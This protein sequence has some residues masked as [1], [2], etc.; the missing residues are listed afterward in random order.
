MNKKLKKLVEHVNML[1][2]NCKEDSPEY[3]L[4]ENVLTDEMIDLAL[5]MKIRTPYTVEMIAQKSKM[6]IETVK[7]LTGKMAYIGFLEYTKLDGKEALSLPVFAPGSMELMVMNKEQVE[8]HP[9]IARSF[10]TYV[11]NLTK[12]FA[13]FFPKGNGLVITIPVQKAIEAEPKRIEIEELTYWV[14]K[15]A[16]SLSVTGCQCRRAGRITNNIGEDKEG[17]WCIQVGEFAESCIKTGRSRRVTKEEAYDILRRAEEMG[18]VHEVTN[19]DGPKNSLFICNCHPETCLAFRTAR[20]IDTPNMMKSN[21]VA[22]VDREKCAACGQCVEVCPMNAAKLGQKLCQKTPVRIQERV[23]ADDHT[24]GKDKWQLDFR[25]T[26]KDVVPETGT[27]PCKTNCPAHISV[28][29]YIRL[30]SEGKYTEALELIKKENPFPAV[31]GRIC[32]RKCEGE[33]TRGDLDTPVAIDE[34]KKFIAEQELNARTRYVPKKR[35]E[36]GEKIA[37]IGAGPAGLSCAFYLA[38]FG[39]KVTV[40]EKQEKLGGMLTLGIPA[41]R[42]EKNVVNAEIDILRE[43]G[44]EFKMGVDVGKDITIPALRN[45]GYKGFYLAIGAQNGRKLK[46][47]GEDADGVISGVDF[48]RNVALDKP[49]RLNGEVVVIGGG[50]V[51]IDVGRTAVRSGAASVNMFCLESASEMPALP[52][53]IEEAT[54]EGIKINNSWGPK[55]FVVENGKVTGVEFKKCVSVFNAQ[56]RFEPK[57]DENDTILVKAD[58]VLVSVG[59]SI[60]WGKMLEGTKIS[61]NGNNTAIADGV[62]Y[63]TAEQNIFVGGDAFTGPKFA[64]DAIAAGKEG[65][66]SLH[67]FVLQGHDLLIGRDRREY[68]AID[69]GNLIIGSYDTTPRQRPAIKHEETPGFADNRQNFTEEQVKKETERCLGC[70]LAVIDQT[71]CLGCGLCTTRCKFDAITLNKVS[72]EYGG[73]YEQLPMKIAGAVTKRAGKIAIRSVR[74]VF[75]KD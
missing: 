32:P 24:W 15:Y 33:C 63:Q 6:P 59:Q 50:N 65:A 20:L 2:L 25:N 52:E 16:P 19:V 23:S 47:E 55:R 57:Y 73:T 70:G 71:R 18:Y 17:E 74:D 66:N 54:A 30:A 60:D 1:N 14:E 21:F 58:Y 68:H 53:E 27:A 42:L 35:F 12:N 40:F 37:V 41:F 75:Y 61:F 44:V 8:A 3:T 46:V 43:L 48:L 26:K 72:S 7:D 67:R 13:R 28:Q 56:K 36:D 10:I 9:E 5:S 4:L 31:C 11:E 39:H 69:K 51:A 34:I 64:I 38:L 49:D 45:G 22:S 62:T 29:G